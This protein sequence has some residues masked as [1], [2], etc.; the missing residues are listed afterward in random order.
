MSFKGTTPGKHLHRSLLRWKQR[1]SQT[2]AERDGE[3]RVYGHE[4]P[5]IIVDFDRFATCV[6]TM[7]YASW[8]VW[9]VRVIFSSLYILYVWGGKL[10]WVWFKSLL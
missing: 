5:S 9:Y 6:C 10:M 8:R 4:F 3:R 7:L 2:R 1:V